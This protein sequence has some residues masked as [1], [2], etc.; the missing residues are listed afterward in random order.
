[1][2]MFL[3]MLK[4]CVTRIRLPG[5]PCNECS[6]QRSR[7]LVRLAPL[8]DEVKKSYAELRGAKFGMA[9]GLVIPGTG[10]EWFDIV[11]MTH[12]CLV[13]VFTLI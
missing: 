5:G 2:V 6:K 7:A 1:M 8:R 13:G 9:I 10:I 12:N 4:N 3:Y 11:I